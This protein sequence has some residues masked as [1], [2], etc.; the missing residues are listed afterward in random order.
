MDLSTESVVRSSDCTSGRRK[1]SRS[2]LNPMKEM[3][4]SLVAIR[5][6]QCHDVNTYDF[7]SLMRPGRELNTFEPEFGRSLTT[8][9]S[10]QLL[11]AITGKTSQLHPMKRVKITLVA[12]RRR[13]IMNTYGFQSI[14]CRGK[15]LN[16]VGLVFGHS[17]TTNRSKWP[18]FLQAIRTSRIQRTSILWHRSISII[19]SMGTARIAREEAL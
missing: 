4:F 19:L 2:K 13:N 1:G 9:R 7:Q 10:S 5:H 6:W 17:L 15:K 14:M 11:L 12:N 8:D 16:I 3:K 18:E